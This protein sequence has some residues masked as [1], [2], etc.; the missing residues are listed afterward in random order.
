MMPTDE[1]FWPIHSIVKVRRITQLNASFVNLEQL[2]LQ[3]NLH[4]CISTYRKV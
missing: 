2:I 3:I 4:L 1:G